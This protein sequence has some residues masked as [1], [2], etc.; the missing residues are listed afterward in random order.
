M[1]QNIHMTTSQAI[2]EQRHQLCEAIVARQ[3]QVR[4]DLAVRYGER[5]RIKCLQDTDHHLDYL[6][7]SLAVAQ[8]LLFAD[9]LAWARAMLAGRNIPVEDLV[10]NMECVNAAL[11]EILE[12][13]S[14]ALA[15]EYVTKGIT[16]LKNESA[17]LPSF[18]SEAQPLALLAREYLA[19][20]LHGERQRASRLIL[21]AVEGG[22]L[23][24]DVYLQVFQPCQHEVGRLWQMNQISVAQEHYCTAAT[25]LIMSQLYPYLF[26]GVHTGRTLVATCIAGDLHEIGVRMVSDL[27]ELSGWDTFYLGANTPLP[28]ILQTVRDNGADVLAISATI[29]PHLTAVRDL[30]GQVRSAP[31]CSKVKIIVG[32]Y[33]FNVVPEMWRQL[34]ADGCARDAAGAI[35]LANNLVSEVRAS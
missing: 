31:D 26:N 30:I 18:I 23:V 24:Q 16:H 27:F 35:E 20:L 4:P 17:A 29:T 8:P 32:G 3:Y 14:A 6:T 19:A 28:G 15:V 2:K 34:G 13:A 33:P 21:D 10:A 11:P 7:E 25:Q 12:P 9:Y 1:Q 5:G 22:V